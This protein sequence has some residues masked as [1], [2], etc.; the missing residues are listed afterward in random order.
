M[1]YREEYY[2]PTHSYTYTYSNTIAYSSKVKKKRIKR[3]REKKYTHSSLDE[4]VPTHTHEHNEKMRKNIAIKNTCVADS[5]SLTHT[6]RKMYCIQRMHQKHTESTM[7]SR[8]VQNKPIYLA[9]Q[10]H[11][12]TH[13]HWPIHVVN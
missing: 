6:R 9:G 11:K 1:E 12:H 3:E 5:M 8:S 13:R 2:V 10:I 4:N 7:K